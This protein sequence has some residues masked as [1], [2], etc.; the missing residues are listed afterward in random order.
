[1][2]LG[3]TLDIDQ[4]T[5]LPANGREMHAVLRVSAHRTEPAA[6]GA[7][8]RSP[9]G[10]P[11]S[12]AEVIVIDC[13]GSMGDP[14]S[15]IMEARRAT[16]R[17]IE[18]LPDGTL[19]AVV[20]GTERAESLYPQQGLAVADT[21]TR[22][23]AVRAVERLYA[24]GGTAI[25][26]WLQHARDLLAAHPAAVRHA[27]LLTDGQNIGESGEDLVRVLA[28]CAG[29]YV[30]DAR[31]IGEDWDADQL[32]AIADALRGSADVIVRESML[33]AHFQAMMHD[34]IQKMVPDLRIRVTTMTN[35]EVGFLKQVYPAET[36]LA[37]SAATYADRV[38]EFAT[39]AWGADDAREYQLCLN[40]SPD[41]PIQ[42]ELRLARVELVRDGQRQA[43]PVAVLG[44]RTREDA[45]HTE[46]SRTVTHYGDQRDVRRMFRDGADAF[47]H[48]EHA[49]AEAQWA[50]A[51]QRATE[52][53][54]D[55]A[56]EVLRDLV[57]VDEAG[58][59]R[60]KQGRQ[61]IDVKRALVKIRR[62]TPS[63]LADELARPA[64]PGGRCPQ[65]GHVSPAGA[66]FCP[67]CGRVLRGGAADGA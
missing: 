26:R 61:D 14:A 38:A 24:A 50:R 27:I 10:P 58:R 17:A 21:R 1:M 44:Y 47:F 8:D 9:A 25:S 20:Q 33:T 39:G 46:V 43:G 19:F 55:V 48:G 28:A 65:C 12:H 4:E 22:T 6:G 63:D 35:A 41:C 40:V 29:Q 37:D 49:A 7:A 5:S 62:T 54:D 2:E 34:A 42:E 60:L 51:L 36:D 53:K 18:I 31:G 11:G 3:F 66:K 15:K 13:S 67:A 23:E 16:A 32:R 57:D 59:V 56:V 45:M 30:C 52:A 64:P